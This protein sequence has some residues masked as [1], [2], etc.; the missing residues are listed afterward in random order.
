MQAQASERDSAPIV[1][2]QRRPG[3]SGKLGWIAFGFVLG[4]G[5][6][7]A[8]GFWSFVTAVT[9]T[10]NAPDRGSL[11]SIVLT[12]PKA[13]D[14]AAPS[15]VRAVRTQPTASR[16]PKD[17]ALTRGESPSASVAV[18]TPAS[19]TPPLPPT[20][21]DS[22]TAAPTTTVSNTVAPTA[23][24]G[25]PTSPLPTDAARTAELEPAPPQPETVSAKPRRKQETP[26]WAAKIITGTFDR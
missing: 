19:T 14:V 2:P 26:A 3:L 16:P 22:S 24:P 11:T 12:S 5:F 20:T 18:S 21:P 25:L 8:V 1:R 6:W 17:I 7:H 23:E 13:N 10:G 4:A 9:L 15:P